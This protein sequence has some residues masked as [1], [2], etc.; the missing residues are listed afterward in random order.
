M[1]LIFVLIYFIA[2]LLQS[3]KKKRD[4]TARDLIPA[5]YIRSTSVKPHTLD[6]VWN[7]KFRL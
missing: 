7:E 3:F 5:K 4:K 1:F 6:P 2:I